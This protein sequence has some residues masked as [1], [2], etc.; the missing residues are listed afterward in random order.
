MPIG[1]LPPLHLRL[2]HLD[3]APLGDELANF[4]LLSTYPNANQWAAV[5]YSAEGW[6]LHSD[7][8]DSSAVIHLHTRVSSC[9]SYFGCFF[10]WIPFE[11]DCR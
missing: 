11:I 5:D 1:I 10:Y 4:A 2:F 9:V 8:V 6:A 3:S 7:W